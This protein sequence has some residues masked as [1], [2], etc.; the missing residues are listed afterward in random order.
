MPIHR[1]PVAVLD[2]REHR[3]R[4]EPVARGRTPVN[5][6]SR[7][8]RRGR[9][10]PCRPRAC[11]RGRD[12]CS[13]RSRS[14][15]RPSGERRGS[16]RPRSTVEP[17]SPR[18]D[19]EPAVRRPRRSSGRSRP[20]SPSFGRERREHPV[21][22]AIDAGAARAE[23]DRALVVLVDRPDAVAREAFLVRVGGELPVLEAVQAARSRSRSRGCPRGPRRSRGR[24]R[25]RGPRP[26]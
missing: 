7:T 11:R 3:R 18:P 10:R 5:L 22:E 23:P 25:R 4:R 20:E 17:V 16:A 21:V 26:A 9:R 8:A 19:P 24:C 2:D 1:S 14:E 13:G 12:T 6:P 15:G